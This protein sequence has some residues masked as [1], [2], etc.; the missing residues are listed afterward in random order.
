MPSMNAMIQCPGVADVA[1]NVTRTVKNRVYKLQLPIESDL[2]IGVQLGK[3]G[4]YL[5]A[6]LYRDFQ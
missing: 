5:T 6:A 2:C 4:V 3:C 1:P